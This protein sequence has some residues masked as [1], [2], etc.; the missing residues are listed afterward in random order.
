MELNA[1]KLKND[2]K[3]LK[4]MLL[5]TSLIFVII[6]SG[7]F[8]SLAQ[9]ETYRLPPRSKDQTYDANKYQL[10]IQDPLKP[11]EFIEV[12][13]G[14]PSETN[15]IYREYRRGPKAGTVEK[16][17]NGK[18]EI[19][20]SSPERQAERAMQPYPLP[21]EVARELDLQKRRDNYQRKLETTE[22]KEAAVPASGQETAPPRAAQQFDAPYT[23][24]FTPANTKIISPAK[25]EPDPSPDSPKSDESKTP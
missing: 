20:W 5:K 8:P 23:D 14:V 2:F 3:I 12:H 21:P 17:V 19:T 1:S 9:V 22:Q 24:G 4:S 6:A 18:P 15:V 10:P 13:S 7:I 25:S 16:M 11:L